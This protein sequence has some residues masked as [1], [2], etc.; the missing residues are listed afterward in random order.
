MYFSQ[1]TKMHILGFC[2]GNFKAVYH[3]PF[4]Y[5]VDGLLQLTF[6]CTYIFGCRDD[7]DVIDEQ[8]FINSRIQAIGD[9]IDFLLKRVT[10]SIL[11]CGTPSSWF[12]MFDRV[13]TIRTRNILS[14]RKA[15]IKFGSLPFNTMLCRSFMI[16]YLQVVSYAFS[17][18]KNIASRCM[19]VS[20][21]TT[22]SIIDLRLLKPHWKLVKRLLDS[23]NQTFIDH[24]FHCFA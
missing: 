17:R 16:S 13:E 14:E 21:L 10:D 19:V 6:C 2:F 1:L 24:S 5:F 9:A 12:W 3:C 23:M 7:A 8:T 18:S 20:N 11:P 4:V 15:L 22:W